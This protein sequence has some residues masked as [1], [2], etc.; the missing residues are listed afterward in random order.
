MSRL[1]VLS[2]DVGVGGHRRLPLIERIDADVLLLLGV[3][4]QSSQAWSHRWQDRYHCVTG[5]ELAT[6]Q[7][8]RPRGAMV[9]ARWPLAD[10]SVIEALPRPER[11][12]T[13][14]IE[15]DG[16]TVVLV[17]WGSPNAAREGFR[18]KMD[19]YR[20]M[21]HW[22]QGLDNPAIVGV[23]TNSHFDPPDPDAP[24]ED[25]ELRAAEH[26]FLAR[27]ASHGLVDVHRI[28]V[29]ADPPRRWL[30]SQLRPA[31]PLATTYIRRPHGRPRGIA[32]G[33]EAGRDFG[34]D[35][36]DRL[37]VSP[38]LRPLACEHLYHEA[39]D[40]GSNHAAL[41]ADLELGAG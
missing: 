16:T 20:H 30:L 34:L 23:N 5:L 1:R 25:D 32:Q 9:A 19:A 41:I 28:L 4:R 29:D 38:H 24:D 7:Q 12:L 13:A 37:F 33:F 27:G 31:G 14:T 15:L 17:A 6:S 26:A 18:A 40:A 11:G 22:L 10:S 21:H 3:S 36:M 8:E 39:I 2:W 35:R